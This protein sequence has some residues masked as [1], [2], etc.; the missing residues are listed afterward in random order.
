[1]SGS[2]AEGSRATQNK[3]QHNHGVGDL[4]RG[5][6]DKLLT[7]APTDTPSGQGPTRHVELNLKRT[8]GT[9]QSGE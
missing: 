7:L 6:Q 3:S 2:D 1:M 4:K 5:A 8:L 9:D